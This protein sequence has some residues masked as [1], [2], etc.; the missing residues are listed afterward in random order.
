MEQRTPLRVA[1]KIPYRSIQKQTF[2]FPA[3][4]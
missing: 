3:Q 1:T 4:R 2:K